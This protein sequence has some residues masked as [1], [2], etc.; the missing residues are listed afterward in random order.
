ML[1]NYLL[2]EVY[3]GLNCVMPPQAYVER[4]TF[5]VTIFVNRAFIDVIK[6]ESGH[7]GDPLIQ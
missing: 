2:I 7:K 5:I 3:Y 4:L 6:I 1:S